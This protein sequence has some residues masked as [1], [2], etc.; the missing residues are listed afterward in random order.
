MNQ[1][2]DLEKRGKIKAQKRLGNRS[3][4]ILDR[5]ATILKIKNKRRKRRNL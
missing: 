5:L 2:M 4:K 1:K 3:Y